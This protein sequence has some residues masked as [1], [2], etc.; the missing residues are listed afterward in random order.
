MSV[1]ELSTRLK[2]ML[3]NDQLREVIDLLREHL[4]ELDG[5]ISEAELLQYAARLPLQRKT[6]LASRASLPQT[7]RQEQRRVVAKLGKSKR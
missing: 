2:E 1:Q 4:P 7:G 5:Q 3:V 6:R